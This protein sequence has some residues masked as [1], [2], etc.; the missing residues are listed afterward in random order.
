MDKHSN[1]LQK[2]VNY[3]CN[4]FYNKASLDFTPRLLASKYKIHVKVTNS[5]RQRVLSFVAP[6][7][8]LLVLH[9]KASKL[10]IWCRDTQHN[11]TQ[12]NDTQHLGLDSDTQNKEKA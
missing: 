7:I 8:Q 12:L 5:D 9:A 2:S 6:Y 4:Q 11:D 3:G 10:V 1:L